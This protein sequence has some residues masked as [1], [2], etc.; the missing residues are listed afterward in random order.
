MVAPAVLFA[1]GTIDVDYSGVI[2]ILMIY[3]LISAVVLGI[4]T[5]IVVIINGRRMKGGIV[6]GALNYL[7]IGMFIVLVGSVSVFFPAYIPAYFQGVLP[8]I[9]NTIGY[10]VM[11][12]AASK[13]LNATKGA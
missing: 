9:L 1:Q 5:S 12:I 13:L 6:G 8:N 11:A 2:S 4:V 10:V 7:G 3:S